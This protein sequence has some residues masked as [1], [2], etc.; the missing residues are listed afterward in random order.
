MGGVYVLVMLNAYF[1]LYW[2]FQEE[3]WITIV[4]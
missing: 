2:E 3:G 4:Q 1:L